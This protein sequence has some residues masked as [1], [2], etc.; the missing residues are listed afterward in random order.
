MKLPASSSNPI[1]IV[2]LISCLTFAAAGGAEA[3]WLVKLLKE[4]GEA[5]QDAAK[6]GSRVGIEALEDAAGVVKRLPK[7]AD[8]DLALAAHAT[9]EGHWTF[10]NRQG[11]AFTAATPDEMARVGKALAPDAPEGGGLNLYLSEDSVFL[12]QGALDELPAGARLNVV[13]GKASYPIVRRGRAGDGGLFVQARENVLVPVGESAAFHEA[14]WQLGRPLSRADVRVLSLKPGSRKNLSWSAKRE[15]AGELPLADEI[16]PER[17]AVQ[18]P[19]IRGQTAVLS[20]RI[21]GDRLYVLPSSGGELALSL[22]GIRKAAADADVNLVVLHSNKP[23]QPGSQNWLWQ[24]IKVDGL[25]K[26]LEK[27]SFGDFLDA[28]AGGRGQLVVQSRAEGEARIIVQA[29]PDASSRDLV[30][31]VGTWVGDAV[32]DVT[33]HIVTEGVEAFMTSEARQKELDSRIV[34][35]VPSDWQFYYIGALVMGVIGWSVARGWWD[36]LWPQ[37]QRA[38]Y[39]ASFGFYAARG[40]RWLVFLFVFLPLVG[41]IALMWALALVVFDWLMMPVRA[42]RWLL[43]FRGT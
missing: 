8:G 3:H 14:I 38:E 4:A 22:S 13:V 6:L 42:I 30:D 36:W 21:E 15:A 11:A 32:S 35:G 39:N 10:T 41:P 17:L 27:N 23:L 25:G 28:L 1:L 31:S 12:R 9:P 20:G 18:L 24:T 29:L 33:G 26:A 2:L 34:P 16:D 37:E 5:G 43:G 40:I 7:H 19:N